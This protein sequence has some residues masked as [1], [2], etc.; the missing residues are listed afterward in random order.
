MT[1]VTPDRSVVPTMPRTPTVDA[2]SA[3][4]AGAVA[5]TA[6]LVGL[7]P[8]GLVVGTATAASH[9]TAA[10]WAGTW[11]IYSGSAHLGLPPGTGVLAGMVA[12]AVAVGLVLGRAS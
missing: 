2:R 1:T 11:L 10:G 12:G 9:D 5:M 7:V 6:L 3:F 4:R 8:Y